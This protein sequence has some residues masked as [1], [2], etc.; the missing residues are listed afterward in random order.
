MV[1]CAEPSLVLLDEPCA[2]LSKSETQEVSEAIRWARGN[3]HATFV[4]IEHDMALV[5]ALADHVFVLHEGRLLAEGTVSE[6][7]ANAAVKAV[8][9]G[10]SK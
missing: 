10:G 8:Y 7:K 3:L 6:I 9:A 4:I 1:L 2:G 5:E